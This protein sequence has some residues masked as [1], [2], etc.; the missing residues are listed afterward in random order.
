MIF[1][2]PVLSYSLLSPMLILLVGALI[3]VL[4][5]ASFNDAGLANS[6]STIIERGNGF[7]CI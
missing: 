1:T 2:T 6:R 5:E 3:G 4:V 7:G